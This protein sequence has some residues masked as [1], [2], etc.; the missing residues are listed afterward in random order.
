M[1]HYLFDAS[2][3]VD[4][5]FTTRE[6]KA[7]R[8]RAEVGKLFE[9]HNRG[10]ARLYVPNVCLAECSKAFAR[11]A[12]ES[13]P[14]DAADDVYRGHV[15]TLLRTLSSRQKGAIRSLMVGREHLENIEDI[16]RLEYR[17]PIRDRARHLSGVDAI[18]IAMGRALARQHGDARVVIVTA[19]KWMAEVCGK[20]RP[21]LPAAVYAAEKPV[22]DA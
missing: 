17:L 5:V 1:R 10:K 3:L 7:L 18:V 12:Y 13:C 4:F 11:A 14:E 15:D 9:Q 20:N 21:A 8:V 16:F 2:A 22:P 6:P 19:E